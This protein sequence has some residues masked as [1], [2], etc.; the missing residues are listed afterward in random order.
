M[1]RT[2]VA[3]VIRF[4]MFVRSAPVLELA[5]AALV[6]VGVN[7]VWGWGAATIVAGAA[8]LLKSAELDGGP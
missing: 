2:L 7:S 1:V 6:V 8:L 5:G 4:V 3:L